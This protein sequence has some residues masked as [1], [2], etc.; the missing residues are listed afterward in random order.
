LLDVVDSA[1]MAASANMPADKYGT[2]FHPPAFN[3]GTSGWISCAPRTTVPEQSR[4]R[5]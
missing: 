4:R 1:T 5:R 3:A 2:Q